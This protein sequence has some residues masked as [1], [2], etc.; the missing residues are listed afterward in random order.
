[1]LSKGESSTSQIRDDTIN[2]LQF[3][4]NNTVR[5]FPV[6]KSKAQSTSSSLGRFGR[7]VR[8][9]PYLGESGSLGY[10][11]HRIS[12]M[13]WNLYSSIRIL[14]AGVQASLHLRLKQTINIVSPHFPINSLSA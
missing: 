6:R 2:D 5:P 1:M 12:N 4:C 13:K 7:A 9:N 14:G 8:L 3:H 10:K 11:Q